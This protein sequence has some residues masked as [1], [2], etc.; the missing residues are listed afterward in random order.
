MSHPGFTR[1]FASV[2]SCD[3]FGIRQQFNSVNKMNANNYNGGQQTSPQHT[4]NNSGIIS[5]ILKH[6]NKPTNN[7]MSAHHQG[8]QSHQNKEFED[9]T[10]LPGFNM[11]VFRS[12]QP[13]PNQFSPHSQPTQS[14]KSDTE[15]APPSVN[16]SNR[17]I[18][19][20][21][22][23]FVASLFGQGQ[24]RPKNPRWYHRGFRCRSRGWRNNQNNNKFRHDDVNMSKNI[25]EKERSSAGKCFNDDS[26]DFVD[27]MDEM[28]ELN[29]NVNKKFETARV[30]CAR[31]PTVEPLPFTICS[32]DDF[33]SIESTKK[34]IR[35]KKSPSP[36]KNIRKQA[37]KGK[38]ADTAVPEKAEP[39]P[40][41]PVE[42]TPYVDSFLLSKQALDRV[43]P[44]KRKGS[45]H[46]ILKSP[47]ECFCV[48][49]SVDT[50]SWLKEKSRLQGCDEVVI[51]M[52]QIPKK[53]QRNS[54][55]CS[56][57]D[58]FIVFGSD[59]QDSPD[60]DEDLWSDSEEE[61]S[62][63]DSDTEAETD[64]DDDD[65]D[66]SVD[67]GKSGVALA[68][69]DPQ[70]EVRDLESG[71]HEPMR[72]KVDCTFQAFMSATNCL[73]QF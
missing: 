7:S 9:F 65:L 12:P 46:S 48:N 31:A 64:D 22:T 47:T 13:P 73:V 72:K 70:K 15:T 44:S 59:C 27:L 21:A 20:P 33:P 62:D 56:M 49:S 23:N 53:K 37:K 25:H 45:I 42:R 67:S 8:P 6:F 36:A 11:T 29:G 2:V 40:M 69:E 3:N 26:E 24:S 61:E 10:H 50:S 38:L 60:C 51:L 18:T 14:N 52:P 71:F 28:N 54:S 39:E 19:T 68:N 32:L 57:D 30:S 41:P 16:N 35:Q 4:N 58:D 43:F 17:C 63:S 1:S 55:E 66:E 34:P 5:S